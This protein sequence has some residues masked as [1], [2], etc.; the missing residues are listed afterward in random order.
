ML[1]EQP[2]I[3][4]EE[5]EVVIRIPE[6]TDALLTVAELSELLGIPEH[7]LLE[8]AAM[9]KGPA[10]YGWAKMPFYRMEEVVLWLHDR[11]GPITVLLDGKKVLR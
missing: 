1:R 8:W 3:A 5:E 2:Q 10:L 11:P 6:A 4:P 9:G 7:T